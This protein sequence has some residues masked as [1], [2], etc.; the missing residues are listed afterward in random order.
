MK[1]SLLVG[2]LLLLFPACSQQQ[3]KEE[4]R[5]NERLLVKDS[6]LNDY[7]SVDDEQI[8][9]FTYP[10]LKEADSA[11]CV[12]FR[13]EIPAVLRLAAV[14]SADSFHVF[15]TQKG[16]KKLAELPFYDSL[17]R[18]APP[19]HRRDSLNPLNGLRIAL[20]PGHIEATMRMAQM[21]GKFI[22]MK[23]SSETGL[24]PVAFNEANMTLCTARILADSL[25]KYGAEVLIT[26]P[27]PGIGLCG[28]T[29]EEWYKQDFRNYLKAETDAGHIHPLL[30]DWYRREARVTD[31]YQKLYVPMD[32]KLRA[33]A[34]NR[35]LP[36]LTLIIHYNVHG[37]DWSNHDAAGN[38]KPSDYNYNMA[39]VPGSFKEGELSS[40]ENRA[41]FCRLL[42]SGDVEK[43]VQLSDFVMQAFE[44]KLRV[45][46]VEE[47]DDLIYLRN[48][49]ILTDKKGVYARNLSLTRQVK[50]VLCYGE[51]LCQDNRTEAAWLNQKLIDVG[52][53]KA[54]SREKQVAEAYFLAVKKYAASLR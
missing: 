6:S 38:C 8:K 33:E 35:F 48:S 16:Q 47:S 4:V 51:S 41:A 10:Y 45:R 11:E 23:P 17:A 7:F 20:D 49:S 32:L 3:Y 14:L 27:Q 1:H 24:I 2:L 29:F 42:L 54:S 39:F 50:G 28:K 40:S 12:I 34:I 46:A 44:E 53:I 43:S 31:I 25:R 37:P 21:E 13:E 36:D 26:R 9:F 19:A 22:K 5:T 18:L 15:Y 52:G 30:A